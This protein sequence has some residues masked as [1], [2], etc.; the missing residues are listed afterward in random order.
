MRELATSVN[1]DTTKLWPVEKV[2][3]GVPRAACGAGHLPGQCEGRVGGCESPWRGVQGPQE[4][5]R[6][7]VNKLASHTLNERLLRCR[8]YEGK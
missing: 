7:F 4:A 8:A 1:I 2:V 5:V 3:I 6:C